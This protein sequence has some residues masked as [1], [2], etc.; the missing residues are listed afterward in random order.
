MPGGSSQ[1]GSGSPFECRSF[2]GSGG[3]SGRPM[4]LEFEP[5][6]LARFHQEVPVSSRWSIALASSL[7]AV[8]VV[9]APAAAGTRCG[10]SGYAYAG[11]Q[12]S[13]SGHGV[14]AVLTSLGAPVVESGH[15]AGWV[16][17]GGPGQGPGGAD[18]WIQVGLNSLPGTGN[19]LYYEVMRPGTGQTYAEI[20]TDVPNGR[21]LR[22]AVLETS[23]SLGS[24]RVWVNGRAVTPAISLPG[25]H[26]SLSPMAMGE[27]WDGGRP[28]CN[29]YAYRFGNVAVAGAPGGSWQAVREPAVLQD[30]GYKVVRRTASSF[31][32]SATV[33][34]P[35]SSAPAP[36]STVSVSVAVASGSV[37]TARTAGAAKQAARPAT[38]GSG[39]ASVPDA[40]PSAVRVLSARAISASAPLRKG[41]V[42]A[43]TLAAVLGVAIQAVADPAAPASVILTQQAST[44]GAP[45]PQPVSDV[46]VLV[47]GDAASAVP[48]ETSV[49]TA[50]AFDLGFG[51]GSYLLPAPPTE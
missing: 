27:S 8:F 16:G 20:D 47:V 30:P 23:T 13:Q 14:S 44:V 18:E 1:P 11:I 33:P 5:V 38:P 32:A 9:A 36:P 19:K 51:A 48:S 17:V 12:P 31:D 37:G 21:S 29:R 2:E 40:D 28:A 39:S 10:P 42:P 15:V 43:P 3:V 46:S 26:G 35:T 45:D 25:S 41:A 7:S 4:A 22:V 6:G 24:W 50:T 49:A 34:P